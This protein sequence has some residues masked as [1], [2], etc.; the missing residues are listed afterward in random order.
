V[1]IRVSGRDAADIV[2]RELDVLD[3]FHVEL[4]TS[5]ANANISLQTAE[6]G[7]IVGSH[8]YIRPDNLLRLAAIPVQGW[9]ERFDEMVAI[10]REL[11]WTDSQSRLRAHMVVGRQARPI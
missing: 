2:V 8:A 3:R 4:A 9:T 1:F 6:L 11:G 5:V 7:E 10:A